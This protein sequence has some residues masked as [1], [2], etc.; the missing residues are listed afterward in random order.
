[1]LLS[2]KAFWHKDR[3]TWLALT[4][5]TSAY[6]N[7]EAINLI[8]NTLGPDLYSGTSGIALF[9]AE[10][11]SA[12]GDSSMRSLSLGAIRQSVSGIDK[13]PADLNLGLYNGVIGVAFASAY[14]GK[15]LGE[16]QLL[17][18][19]AQ[20]LNT[21]LARQ[22][23][24]KIFDQIAGNAG[25]ISALL[26]LKDLLDDHNL[27]A[28]AKTL[29]DELVENA[30]CHD[31]Y[32][33]W[34]SPNFPKQQN[35]LGFSHGTA[36]IAYALIELFNATGEMNYKK[37]AGFAFNYEDYWYNKEKDNWPD[38]RG[39]KVSVNQKAKTFNFPVFWCHGA[40]GIAIS[41]LM[42]HKI[43]KAE[44]Y[45]V[46]ALTALKITEE[47]TS[48]MLDREQVNWCLCHGLSGNADILLTGFEVLGKEF[49]KGY[50]LATAVA[51]SGIRFYARAES[52]AVWC[53][54]S[55][56]TRADVRFKWGRPFLSSAS[57]SGDTLFI[58]F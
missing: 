44:N 32:C 28:F 10:L 3:C 42:A 47:W 26:I 40:P 33:S 46:E 29:G 21:V 51:D 57:Q 38:F 20:I 2:S 23:Q 15:L 11:Y 25:A 5:K 14:I 53:I 58:G 49:S 9:L 8:Y 1:M 37:I 54:G 30:V 6:D 22:Q 56:L 41:R 4:P 55:Q 12:T 24:I 17:K 43:F 31:N 52:L 7:D 16:E 36:G 50:E 19:A 13:I 48:K 34:T 45:K 27:L 18:I 39:M 35:L